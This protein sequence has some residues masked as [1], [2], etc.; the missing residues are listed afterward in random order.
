MIQRI[1]SIYL[2]VVAILSAVM[3]ALPVGSF[4][5]SEQTTADLYNLYIVTPE[6]NHD[7]RVWALFALLLIVCGITFATIFLYKKRMLQIRLCIFSILLLIGYYATLGSFLFLLDGVKIF[8]P[9]IAVCFPLVNIILLWLAIRAIGK[10][11]ILVKAYER[12]R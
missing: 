1:Q 6:G 5:L 9:Q 2:L 4:R 12:L 11:E 10:D 7:Y 3:L 8:T